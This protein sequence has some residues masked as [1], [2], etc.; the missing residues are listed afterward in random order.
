MLFPGI[1]IVKLNSKACKDLTSNLYN[2]FHFKQKKWY[3]NIQK[4]VT[5]LNRMCI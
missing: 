1:D 5:I 4:E 2:F 3:N